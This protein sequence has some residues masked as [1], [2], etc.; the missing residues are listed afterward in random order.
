M[1]FSGFFAHYFD[2]L[3]F[4]SFTFFHFY[5]S[6]CRFFFIYRPFQSIAVHSRLDSINHKTCSFHP[7][8]KPRHL[9]PPKNVLPLAPQSAWFS[10]PQRPSP[11][12][13][14]SLPKCF[15]FTQKRWCKQ[16][17][18]THS[19]QLQARICFSCQRIIK[20]HCTILAYAFKQRSDIM[21]LTVYSVIPVEQR[22]L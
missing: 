12:W 20:K 13:Y 14:V 8:P 3:W 16:N 1:S 7:Q 18:R 4:I 5:L 9:N 10:C 19:S 17:V 15:V 2:L 6:V 22:P 11:C 21:F